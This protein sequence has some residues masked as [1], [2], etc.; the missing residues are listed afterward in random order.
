MNL[1]LQEF[2]TYIF[3][4]DGVIFNSNR[5]KTEGFYET[6]KKYGEENSKKLVK[7]PFDRSFLQKLTL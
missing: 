6:T 3:D 1:R 7:F 5:I 2:S 4:C